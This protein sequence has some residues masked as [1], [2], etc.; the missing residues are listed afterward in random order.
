MCTTQNCAKKG[1]WENA[2]KNDEHDE[3]AL[4]FVVTY[5]ETNAA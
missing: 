2:S 5:L 1:I 3:K 4:D